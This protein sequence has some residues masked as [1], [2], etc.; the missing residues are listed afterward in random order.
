MKYSLSL[1]RLHPAHHLLD[2]RTF[3]KRTTKIKTY[4]HKIREEAIAIAVF[5]AVIWGVFLLDR[6]LPLEKLGLI[7]RE[8]SGIFGIATM[9]FLHVDL[10]HIIGNTLPLTTLL[11]LLAGSRA[12]SRKAV[13]LITIIGGALLWLFGRDA[14]H[15]GASLLIFGLASFLLVSGLLEKRII[16]MIISIIIALVYG[17]TM[18]SGI[19]P[20][21]TG[22]SWEGHLFGGIAGAF[23]AWVLVKKVI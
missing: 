4:A 16:P 13:V 2:G 10:G 9:T 19:L 23:T 7:P 5:I 22:V 18:L 1:L 21:Q 11:A 20:W 15:I 17:T 14:I 3:S 8:L 12:D 6:F